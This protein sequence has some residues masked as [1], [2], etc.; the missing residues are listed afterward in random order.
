[1]VVICLIEIGYDAS[2]IN[3][4]SEIDSL[5]KNV[6]HLVMAILPMNSGSDKLLN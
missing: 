5:T 3:L 2:K 4:I 1:M 6:S